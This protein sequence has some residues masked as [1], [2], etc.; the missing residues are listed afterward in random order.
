MKRIFIVTCFLIVTIA[1]ANAQRRNAMQNHKNI[2]K[3]GINS[4]FTDEEGLP[5]MVGWEL[6]T[7]KRQS[8]LLNVAPR[9][10][11]SDDYKRTGIGVGAEYRFYIS[12]NK[13]GISGVYF[14]PAASFGRLSID[15]TYGYYNGSTFTTTRTS[16]SYTYFNVGAAFGH[17]WVWQ[18]GFALDLGLGT[19]FRISDDNSQRPYYYYSSFGREEGFIPRANVTIGYAF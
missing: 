7:N 16:Y 8:I 12:K 10:Y 15:D 3:L 13:T 17:Q 19:S 5:L 2:P 4:E 11:R 9:Y 18:S 14:G 6:K 1:A